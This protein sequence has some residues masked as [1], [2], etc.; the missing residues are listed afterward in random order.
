LGRLDPAKSPGILLEA[1]CFAGMEGVELHYFG[2]GLWRASLELVVANRPTLKGRVFFHGTVARPQEALNRMDVLWLPST[3]EG[4]GLVVIE[5]MASGVP[6]V[7]C[8]GGGVTDIVRDGENGLLTDYVSASRT[9][10]GSLRLLR[11]DV[12]LREKLIENGLRTVRGR[13]S[14]EVVLPQYRALL[15]IEGEESG[16]SLSAPSPA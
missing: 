8:A 15:G 4:F 1:M 13:F 11:E 16:S 12:E 6:V 2:D 5:A 7:A 10:A 14:W 3:V 9:F